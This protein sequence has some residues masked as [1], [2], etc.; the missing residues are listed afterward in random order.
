MCVNCRPKLPELYQKQ[1][2][3]DLALLIR[4]RKHRLFRSTLPG[5]GRNVSVVKGLCTRTLFVLRQIA[6]YITAGRRG[7]RRWQLLLYNWIVLP[8]R[9]H[10]NALYHCYPCKPCPAES[11]PSS[12]PR[13]VDRDDECAISIAQFCYGVRSG[14]GGFILWSLSLCALLVRELFKDLV[15]LLYRWYG[16]DASVHCCCLKVWRLPG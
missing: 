11:Y 8:R 9:Q 4:Y 5:Y 3:D 16:V 7:R 14:D 15:Q 13:V 1:V 12:V 2:S 10:G 6:R